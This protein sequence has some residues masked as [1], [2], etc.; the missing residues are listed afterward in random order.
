MTLVI[1]RPMATPLVSRSVDP[2]DKYDLPSL[3]ELFARPAWHR[4]ALCLE[5]PEVDWFRDA[6]ILSAKV[7]CSRCLVRDEYAR[8]GI[9][10]MERGVWG[11]LTRQE[12]RRL[13][14]GEAA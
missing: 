6:D 5:H 1:V 3:A 8:A 14:Q 13:V 9:A 4:D 2:A 11:G 7:I 10:E 12:R